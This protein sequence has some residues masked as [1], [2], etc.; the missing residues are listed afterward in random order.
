MVC[1]ICFGIQVINTTCL[2]VI[3]GWDAGLIPET[4]IKKHILE[5]DHEDA[6]AILVPDTAVPTLAIIDEIEKE[7]GKIVLS[8]NQVTLW[9]ALR[10]AGAEFS[11][12]RFGKLFQE[13][14]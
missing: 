12:D 9:N 3:G 10:L 4:E 11:V 2:G 13:S 5:A 7:T 14:F 1:F 8:A 6:E